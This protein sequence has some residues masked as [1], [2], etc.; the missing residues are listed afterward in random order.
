M[1]CFPSLFQKV[2]SLNKNKNKQTHNLTQF[3]KEQF[4]KALQQTVAY[5]ERIAQLEARMAQLEARLEQQPPAGVPL[6]PVI[7]EQLSK[8]ACARWM[9]CRSEII[10]SGMD[11]GMIPCHYGRHAITVDVAA[12][13]RFYRQAAGKEPRPLREYV[14]KYREAAG[15]PPPSLPI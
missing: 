9:G 5:V 4:R 10:Q 12:C 14:K 15:S 7:P 3:K 1:K 2:T 13:V 6:P 8:S 11:A